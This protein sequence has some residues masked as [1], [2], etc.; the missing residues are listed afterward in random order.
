MKIVIFGAGAIGSYFGASLILA[1]HEVHFLERAASAESLVKSGIS[2][3]RKGMVEKV[4][5][6][7]VHTTFSGIKD[8]GPFDFGILAV[9]SYD[10]RKF[11]ESIRG[12][13]AA[14]PPILCLQNGVENESLIAETFGAERVIAGSVTTAIG[15]EGPG[16]ITVE[17]LR[18]VGIAGASP[19]VPRIVET[20][21]QAGLKARRYETIPN[22]KWS[23]LLTNLPANASAAI[24]NMMP[25]EIFED[26]KLFKLEM[27]QLQET[28]NVMNALGYSV[29]DL[30]GT[31]VKLLALGCKFSGWAGQAL[32]GGILA[33][34]RGN[35]KPS[36]LI[37][38]QSGSRNSEVEF[39]NGVVARKG[40][41]IG[42]PT[43]VNT[44]Y[45]R[46]L[47][48]IVAGKREWKLLDHKPETLIE[49]VE[50]EREVE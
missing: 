39:L 22:M 20:F 5:G 46:V 11:L 40:K 8:A 34:G 30:P 37:E 25:V 18:G 12:E 42:I 49:L 19:L 15:R 35:K 17:K 26:S 9:K 7:Q 21:H 29:E 32:F 24:L 48:E 45:T 44:S 14:I 31:P 3:Y 43:P 27:E 13:S 2:L 28:I 36:F 6:L 38:M 41:E 16:V 4:S 1:G 50:R 10:T 33:R 23:K 47:T